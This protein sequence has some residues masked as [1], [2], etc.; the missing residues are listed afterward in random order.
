MK[1][2]RLSLS[3]GEVK[4]I[5]GMFDQ[6]ESEWGPSESRSKLETKIDKFL[7]KP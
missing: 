1:N 4:K 3:I 2:R 6:I 7:E 5:K